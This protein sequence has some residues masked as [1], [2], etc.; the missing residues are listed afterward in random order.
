MVAGLTGR[1]TPETSEFVPCEVKEGRIGWPTLNVSAIGTVLKVRFA[2][3]VLKKSLFAN[4]RKFSGPLVRLSRFDVRD[5]IN[6]RKNDRWPS[7]RFYR[8]LQRLKSSIRYIFEI[9]GVSRF[10]SFST[11]SATSRHKLT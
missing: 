6:C 9:F 5:H 11:Q 1:R 10:S 3:I 8:A 7:H 2:P 4:G